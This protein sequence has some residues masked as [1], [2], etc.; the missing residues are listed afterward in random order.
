MCLI[1]TT[2]IRIRVLGKCLALGVVSTVPT[3][4]AV[5]AIKGE[6]NHRLP[7]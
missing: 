3:A 5:E 1:G 7:L 4:A 2:Q 6:D